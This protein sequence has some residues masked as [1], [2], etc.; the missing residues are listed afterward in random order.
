MMLEKWEHAVDNEKVFGALLTDLSKA[1]DCVSHEFLIAKLNAYGLSLPALK[2]V[3]NYLQNHKQRTKNGT[4]YSLWKNF[5]SGV[6]QGLIKESPF[7]RD[8]IAEFELTLKKK[9]SHELSI[10]RFFLIPTFLSNT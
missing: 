7:S 8:W 6:P 2:L 4:A 5:F 3:S 1:F 9:L 10:L